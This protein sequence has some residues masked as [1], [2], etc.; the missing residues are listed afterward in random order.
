MSNFNIYK[1]SAGSGKTYTLVK[2]YIKKALINDAKISHKP[3]LAITFTNKA[4]SEM[5]SRIISSLFYFSN[6]Y[7]SD[8]ASQ[9]LYK[10]L[11]L[12]LGYSDKVLQD[13]S[14]K[15]LLDIIHYYG[16]FSVSTIDKFV[17]KVIKGFSYELDLPSSFTVEMDQDKI[18][19]EGVSAVIDEAGIDSEL[20]NGLLKYSSYKTTENKKWDIEEDLFQVSKEL[21]KDQKFVFINKVSDVTAIKSVQRILFSE[22]NFFEKEIES[23]ANKIKKLT[24][25]ISSSSFYYKDLPNY[26]KKIN[27]KPYSQIEISDQFNKRLYHSIQKNKWYKND[28]TSEDKKSIDNISDNL[29]IILND[30][31]QFLKRSYSAYRFYKQCYHSFF[32]V[33][34]LSKIDEKIE[35]IKKENNIIHISEFNQIILRFLK[36]SPVP[37]IYEKIDYPWFGMIN[38]YGEDISFQLR[39]KDAGIDSYV[40]TSIIVGHEKSVVLDLF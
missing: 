26:L 13:K 28:A 29:H 25:G 16:L 23:V 10:D 15:I 40:D 21:F 7:N 9:K 38:N 1:A 6:K 14:K 4:A 22:I 36:E 12:E 34:V 18:I 35:Y 19:Q 32:L 37:F 33:S 27:K 17:H 8:S 2:E 39:A 5:K 11:K 24:Q 30:L 20:T 3:L 31:I